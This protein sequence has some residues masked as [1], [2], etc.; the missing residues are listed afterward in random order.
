MKDIK[1]FLKKK[2]KNAKK[3]P[4]AD[5][6]IF[7]KRKKNKKNASIIVIG[8]IGFCQVLGNGGYIGKN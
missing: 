7:L 5:I 3:S 2:N 1:I 8:F 4:E 6:K